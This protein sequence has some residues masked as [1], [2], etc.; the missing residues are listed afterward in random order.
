MPSEKSSAG[1]LTQA[2]NRSVLRFVGLTIIAFA[3][4]AAYYPALAGGFILD[5]DKLVTENKFI[6]ADNGLYDYWFTSNTMDYWPLTN[7][8]FWLEWRLWRTNSTG[9][10]ITNLVLHILSA[11][12]VWSI[13][14]QLS[15][16]GAFL[17]ALLFAIHPVNVQSV[18]WISERKNTLAMVFFLLA[19]FWYLKSD[20]QPRILENPRGRAKQWFWYGLSFLAFLLAMLSKGSV[21]ILPIV[22]VGILWWRHSRISFADCLWLAPFAVLAAALAY[23]NVWFQT[24]GAAEPIR[25]IGQIDRVL[26]AGTATWFYLSKAI[27][28]LDLIFIY[29]QWDIEA[30]DW[31][32]WI[33]LTTAAS[34]MALLLWRRRTAWGRPLLFAYGLFIV[35]LLPVLGLVDVGFLR[36]SPV[37]DHYQYIAII[38]VLALAAAAWTHWY[39]LT[40]GRWCQIAALSAVA[41]VGLLGIK[42][43]QQCRLYAD[44]MAL[45]EATLAK[46]PRSWLI[47]NDLGL[48]Y[49]D[50][51]LNQHAMQDFRRSAQPVPLLRELGNDQPSP[52]RPLPTAG[53]TPL[54]NLNWRYSGGPIM[55]T[56][57]QIWAQSSH[58]QAIISRPSI[59]IAGPS[60]WR[61]IIRIHAAT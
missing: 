14:R 53:L 61:Q 36:H 55:Q 39:D 43:W 15:I 21:A 38:S 57:T 25:S 32:W 8:T 52:V 54:S 50:Q 4:I 26:G 5:D 29:P 37:A 46:N 49:D 7:T 45:Y 35:G 13:L 58:A 16:P 10:H 47:H 56:L 59:I 44:G 20:S 48:L 60:N 12:L 1:A 28:P 18:T 27:L 33:P 19:I 6:R 11:F 51:E 40:H 9:Y 22:L 24:H 41:I 17:A 34:A 3:A 23:V 42:T 30:S 2:Q 31:H